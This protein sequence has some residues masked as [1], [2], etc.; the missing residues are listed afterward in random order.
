MSGIGRCQKQTR[1]WSKAR[2]RLHRLKVHFRLVDSNK[3][4]CWACISHV[5]VKLN[6]TH[7][8][9]CA[10]L[11]SMC[12]IVFSMLFNDA[13]LVSTFDAF[14]AASPKPGTVWADCSTIYPGLSAELAAK[15]AAKGVSFLS[16]PIFGRPDAIRM[17]KGLMACAG[18]PAARERVGAASLMCRPGL[19]IDCL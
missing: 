11:A 16:T 15:G 1:W 10:D 8:S 7:V 3:L 17:H 18:D 6:E 14:L 13:A 12:S 4:M 2:R 19:L 9:A 5:G